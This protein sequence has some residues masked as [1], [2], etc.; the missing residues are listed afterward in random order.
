M[1]AATP[2]ALPTAADDASRWSHGDIRLAGR[3][4]VRPPGEPR[5]CLR[6]SCDSVPKVGPVH[7][8]G[9]AVPE[10]NPQSASTAGRLAS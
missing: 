7:L 1:P 5:E 2:L 4:T 10:T 6:N 9:A 3:A 8:S